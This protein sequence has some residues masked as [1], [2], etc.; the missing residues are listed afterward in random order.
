M[1]KTYES[2]VWKYIVKEITGQVV[3][4]NDDEDNAVRFCIDHYKPA[5]VIKSVTRERIYQNF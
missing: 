1:D 2:Q 5:Y 4:Q 3:Y